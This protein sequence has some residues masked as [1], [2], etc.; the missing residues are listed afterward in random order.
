MCSG[1]NYHAH[2]CILI[3]PSNIIARI[4]ELA[5]GQPQ[6]LTF[7]DRDGNPIPDDV[8]DPPPDTP[9]EIPGVLG[10]VATI[11]GVDMD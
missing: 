8:A 3:M 2:M 1:L 4:H 5:A 6:V 7:A 9:H 10:D 11:P